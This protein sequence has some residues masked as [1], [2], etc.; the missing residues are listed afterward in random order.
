MYPTQ[1]L[2]KSIEVPNFEKL[3]YTKS[4]SI[5]CICINECTVT[6]GVG[7]VGMLLY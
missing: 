5:W 6:W 3:D 7:V 1:Y 2:L 4:S